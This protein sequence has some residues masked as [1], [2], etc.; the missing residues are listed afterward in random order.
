MGWLV[1]NLL[2]LLANLGV[3][4]VA[5]KLVTEASKG[6]KLDAMARGERWK[7]TTPARRLA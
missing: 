6:R 5:V 7:G 3:L 1:V 2:V 4:Q